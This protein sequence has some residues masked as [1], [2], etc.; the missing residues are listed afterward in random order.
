MYDQLVGLDEDNIAAVE[1]IKELE[2]ETNSIRAELTK[3]Q[4]DKVCGQF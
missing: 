1:R 4:K 3:S 2:K